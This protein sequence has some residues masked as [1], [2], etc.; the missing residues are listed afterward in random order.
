MLMQ[1]AA[2]VLQIN[3]VNRPATFN[4]FCNL[5]QPGKQ[6]IFLR[7]VLW[8]KGFHASKVNVV[9]T[10]NPNTTVHGVLKKLRLVFSEC[11]KLF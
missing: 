7:P 2:V 3:P 4:S 5:L 8:S 9:A 11:Q 1:I 10:K 6:G